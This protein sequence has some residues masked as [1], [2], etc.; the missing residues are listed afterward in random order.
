MTADPDT[1]TET[2]RLTVES[3]S[4]LSDRVWATLSTLHVSDAA[5]STLA[6]AAVVLVGARL[7]G[8]RLTALA[9]AGGVCFAVGLV[10]LASDRVRPLFVGG[11]VVVPAAAL[12]TAALGAGVGFGAGAATPLG[13]L[14]GVAVLLVAGGAFAATFTIV[15]SDAATLLATSFG[16]LFGL[17]GP[18]LAVGLVAAAA[19]LGDASFVTRLAVDSPDPVLAV[20]RLLLAPTGSLAL[21]T[22]LLYI[23]LSLFTLRVAVVTLPFTKLA[24]PRQRPA[25]SARTHEVGTAL[26]W[27]TLVTAGV[28]AALYAAAVLSGTATPGAIARLFGPP[29]GAVVADLLTA[30]WLRVTLVVW[31]GLVGAVL[32]AERVRRRARR[33]SNADFRRYGFAA[34]GVLTAVLVAGVALEYAVPAE[35]LRAQALAVGHPAVE[36][37]LAGGV[38][39]V[40]V[41]TTVAALV[42]AG[43]LLT[44]LLVL[45]ASPIVPERALA[46]AL[47][48]GTV[49]A[50][51][52]VLALLGGS[53]ALAVVAVVLSILV[54]DTGEYATG[55]REELPD[56][57]ATMRGELVHAGA[58]VGIGVLAVVASMAV[59]AVVEHELLAPAMSSTAGV[60]GA[61]AAVTAVALLSTLRA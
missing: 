3:G 35:R 19:T 53:A 20:A 28:S 8:G 41:L 48:A 34:A 14:T 33:Y 43:T 40:V 1:R 60:A 6:L 4:S 44:V 11:F 42:V 52:L 26:G 58:S 50:L 16:R 7:F 5:S 17:F 27:A 25:V 45:G 61:L 2:D 36:S 18:L 30:V 32:L 23:V 10:A 21:L 9:A 57:A 46:P 22:V 47:G 39:P 13:H 37:L 15:P 12:L 29:V 38:F 24:P 31:L 54:W 51:A 56:G 59:D 49:F 55:L